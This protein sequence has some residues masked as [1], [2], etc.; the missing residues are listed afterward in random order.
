MKP[1][2]MALFSIST[3]IASQSVINEN[4]S[5]EGIV[6]R[7]SNGEPLA[8]VQVQLNRDFGATTDRS[9]H[10]SFDSVTPGAYKIFAWKSIPEGAWTND[11]YLA[12]YE[13]QG[14]AVLAAEGNPVTDVKVELIS[15]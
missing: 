12:Q 14:T 10:F 1:I 5:V 15:N 2:L 9:G 8:D 3:L 4:G 11:K 13:S 6:R 7:A